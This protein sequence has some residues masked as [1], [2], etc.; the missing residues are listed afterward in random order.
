MTARELLTAAHEG[1]T[2][3]EIAEH[4]LKMADELE[5]LARMI[6]SQNAIVT[7][8][9]TILRTQT[10]TI[11]TINAMHLAGRKREARHALAAVAATPDLEPMPVATI[12]MEWS[13]AMFSPADAQER[14]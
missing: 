11:R 14:H 4:A 2:P 3:A 6:T 9:C 8:V 10:N 12:T 1:M 7:S 5:A 13:A